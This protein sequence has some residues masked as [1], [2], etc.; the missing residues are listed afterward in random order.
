MAIGSVRSEENSVKRLLWFTIAL[1]WGQSSPPSSAPPVS[2]Y[3]ESAL[4]L[5]TSDAARL[6]LLIQEEDSLRLRFESI[7][8]EKEVIRLR[9]CFAA[10]PRIKPEQCGKLMQDGKVALVPL[11]AAPAKP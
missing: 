11:P 3:T 6:A 2:P 7:Q 10:E 8:Q 5:S 1:A 9:T 4:P